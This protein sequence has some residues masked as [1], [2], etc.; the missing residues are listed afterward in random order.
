MEALREPLVRVTLLSPA[1]YVGP[2][3]SLCEE[4]GASASASARSSRSC[5]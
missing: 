2:L 3:I 5:S 4:R 1:E